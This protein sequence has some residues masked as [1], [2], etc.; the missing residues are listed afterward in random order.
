MDRV[1]MIDANQAMEVLR[2]GE[3]E[4]YTLLAR[5]DLRAYRTAGA[6]RFRCGDVMALKKDNKDTNTLVLKKET[7]GIPSWDKLF[8]SM[9]YLLS[10]KSKDDSS[11][12]G[13]F[14]IGPYQEI[15]SAGYNGM[16][17]G[18]DD[19]VP[20]RHVRPEKYKWMRHAEQNAVDIAARIGNSLDGC[21]MY[22]QQYPC[23]GC[24]TS[25]IQSGIQE[26][27]YHGECE[28]LENFAEDRKVVTQMFAEAGVVIRQ[29]D[30]QIIRE[31]KG[32]FNG[33]TF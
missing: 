20:E 9:V 8:M 18:V 30:G 23:P 10:M 28:P 1:D 4:L 16:P 27:V 32:Q 12:I 11:K 13:A 26:V 17:R 33:K 19:D 25:I 2:I 29:Y 5:G 6:M 7:P 31:I 24:A 22:T 14:V 15:R 3:N 21:V